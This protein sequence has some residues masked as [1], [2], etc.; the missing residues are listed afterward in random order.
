MPFHSLAQDISK[1]GLL[2]LAVATDAY[3]NDHPIQKIYLQF[4]KPYYATGDTIWFKAWLLN[5]AYLTPADKTGIC[6][7][8]LADQDNKVVQR[9]M[10]P[11]HNG[12]TWGSITLDEKDIPEGRYTI[13]AYTSLMCNFGDDYIFKK[14]FYFFNAPLDDVLVNA[15]T[16]LSEDN[17]MEKAHLTLQ[18][19]HLNKEA[20]VLKQMNLSV[21]D[22]QRILFKKQVQT[23]V[24]GSL[25]VDLLLKSS[26]RHL[27]LEFAGAPDSVNVQKLDVPVVFNRPKT[28]I[29]NSCP[30]GAI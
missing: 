4:D 25:N 2:K 28:L 13:R 5:A 26:P 17:E 6:Y 18:F 7:V 3:R 19:N 15:K 24:D 21:T 8:E 11:V 9:M 23:M 10:L 27:A 12:L 1:A 16:S 30:K 20:L 29:F 14:S 22:G